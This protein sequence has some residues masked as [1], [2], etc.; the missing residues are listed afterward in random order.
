MQLSVTDAASILNVSEKTIYRWL[1]QGHLP[2]QSVN[3]QHRFNRAELLE[4]ATSRGIPV[5]EGIM[6]DED[7]PSGLVSLAEAIELG[8]VHGDVAGADKDG[9]LRAVIARMPF[10]EEVDREALLQVLLA[11]ES[12]GSTGIGNGIAIPH[13]RNP[14]VLHVPK[15]LVSLCFL[16]QPI[17]FGAV[18]GQ[19][20]HTVFAIISPSIKGHLHLLS[21]LA[22]ALKHGGFAE[23]LAR[24]AAPAEVL[25]QCRLAEARSPKP[26][27]GNEG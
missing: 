3:D 11:R 25:A 23:A 15:A 13:V 7:A 16:R 5:S 1:K 19:P 4:W 6:A 26:Q 24:K 27:P 22:L 21:R 2:S 10:P 9:V 17:E 18:D 14:I 12:M 8:G 20:V